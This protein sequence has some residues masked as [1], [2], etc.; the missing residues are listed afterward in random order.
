VGW[1]PV[2]E[3]AQKAFP[4]VEQIMRTRIVRPSGRNPG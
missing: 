1:K 3:A 2:P 4:G